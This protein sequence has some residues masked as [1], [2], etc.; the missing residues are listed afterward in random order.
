MIET[1][2]NLSIQVMNLT[3][4]ISFVIQTL[5][6]ELFRLEKLVSLSTEQQS[7]IQYKQADLLS[8]LSE[9]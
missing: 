9:G 4:H 3:D 2:T 1:S 5:R 6:I 7:G 8:I